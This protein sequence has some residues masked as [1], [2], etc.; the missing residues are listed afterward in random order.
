MLKNYFKIAWRN[1]FRN[2]TS[3]F[4]NIKGLAIGMSV[5]RCR[6]GLWI[7]D[8]LSFNKYFENYDRIA[9]VMQ[10]Q[11]SNGKVNTISAMPFPIGEELRT[12]YGN[13]FKYVIMSSWTSDHIIS[14]GEKNCPEEAFIC[15]LQ[16]LIC[17]H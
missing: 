16:R 15:N 11:T 14:S 17:Y 4:I 10:H 1:L 12:Q 7:W 6:I 3:S 8:E 13:N 9:K 2:K 5:S